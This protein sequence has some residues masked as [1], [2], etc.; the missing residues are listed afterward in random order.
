MCV[1]S[2]G[3]C[4]GKGPGY[5]TGTS[6][7][8]LECPAVTEVLSPT[9]GCLSP[10]RGTPEAW[11]PLLQLPPHAEGLLSSKSIPSDSFLLL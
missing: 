10:A 5:F 9:H 4:L 1:G 8:G 6:R 7:A 2:W 3:I 11:G